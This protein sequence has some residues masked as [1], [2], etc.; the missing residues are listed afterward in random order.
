MHREKTK[1]IIYMWKCNICGH[2]NQ[3]NTCE[4]CGYAKLWNKRYDRISSFMGWS[5]Y[6]QICFFSCMV[7]FGGLGILD[8]G[9]NFCRTGI[10]AAIA[11]FVLGMIRIY[12]RRKCHSYDTKLE[13]LRTQWK[14]NENEIKSGIKKIEMVCE[15]GR[16]YPEGAVFCAVDGKRLT[17]KV[18]DN[19]VWTCPNCRKIFPDGIKYCPA[20]GRELVKSPKK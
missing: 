14:N 1:T 10:I 13:Q 20:C 11:L 2:P 15:C 8:Q 18:V 9:A 12:V 3:G 16:F 5:V 7:V 17:K 19:Y 4:E 6:I